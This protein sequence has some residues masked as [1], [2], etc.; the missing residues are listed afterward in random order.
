MVAVPLNKTIYTEMMCPGINYFEVKASKAQ[1][2][3]G[4]ENLSI[5]GLGFN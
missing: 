3:V 1:V 4:A 5:S 2:A